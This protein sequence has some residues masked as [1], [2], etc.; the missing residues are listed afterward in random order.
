MLFKI[1]VFFIITLGT[2]T[3]PNSGIV[4][5]EAFVVKSIERATMEKYLDRIENPDKRN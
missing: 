5:K 2:A 4:H 3:T 1:L